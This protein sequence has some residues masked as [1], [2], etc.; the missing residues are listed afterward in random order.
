MTAGKDERPP[1]NLNYRA[2][3]LEL[4]RRTI[5]ESLEYGEEVESRL[6]PNTTDEDRKITRERHTRLLQEITER[7][8]EVK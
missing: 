1:E 7:Q 4:S 5:E 2:I 3:S 6:N 8:K